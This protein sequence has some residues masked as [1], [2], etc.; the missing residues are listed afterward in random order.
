MSGRRWIRFRVAR[1]MSSDD[2][3]VSGLV[4]ALLGDTYVWRESGDW[5][6]PLCC[7]VLQLGTM[8][9]V[10]IAGEYWMSN[11]KERS[12]VDGEY[13]TAGSERTATRAA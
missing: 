1:A 7:L 10:A 4:L 6:W 2:V 13:G 9:A 12:C 11:S 3:I 5:S 8:A